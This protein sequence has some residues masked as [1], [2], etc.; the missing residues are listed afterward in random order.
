MIG[1]TFCI[2]GYV[3]FLKESND[4]EFCTIDMN[5]EST[6]NNFRINV[7]KD[8]NSYRNIIKGGIGSFLQL[9]G[10]IIENKNQKQIEMK[11]RIPRTLCPLSKPEGLPMWGGLPN[12]LSALYFLMCSI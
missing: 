12:C 1:K 10:D 3:K 11:I 6:I 5:D 7:H 9:R 2:N 8:V 4:G